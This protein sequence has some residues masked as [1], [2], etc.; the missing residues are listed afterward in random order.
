[1]NHWSNCVP[2]NWACPLPWL[3]QR[4]GRG[5][6][7]IRRTIWHSWKNCCEIVCKTSRSTERTRMR[8]TIALLFL[9]IVAGVP[10]LSGYAVAAEKTEDTASQAATGP[11]GT[12]AADAGQNANAT[13]VTALPADHAES[14]RYRIRIDYPELPAG[15][16]ALQ[17]KLHEVGQA[18]KCEFM[19]SLPDPKQFPEFAD[20]QLQL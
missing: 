6:A 3:R 17:T 2:M 18:A 1:R 8:Q 16:A 14:Q 15:S 10:G 12:A 20:R 7:S 9:A 13:N 4:R 5:R 19:Q 11:N